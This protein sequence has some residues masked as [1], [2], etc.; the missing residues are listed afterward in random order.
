M[1]EAALELS[2]TKI[3]ELVEEEARKP[4]RKRVQFLAKKEKPAFLSEQQK[5]ELI[6][7]NLKKTD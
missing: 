5:S 1:N 7:K 4:L 6:L 3:D 2:G